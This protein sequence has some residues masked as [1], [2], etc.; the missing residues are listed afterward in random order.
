MEMNRENI[1]TGWDGHFRRIYLPLPLFFLGYIISLLT[2][3]G[4]I[5]YIN[6]FEITKQI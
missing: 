1:A 5:F 3:V 4:V 6:F 2:I